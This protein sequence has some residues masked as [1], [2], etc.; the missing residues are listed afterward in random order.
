[1]SYFRSLTKAVTFRPVLVVVFSMSLI[2]VARER[3]GWPAHSRLIKLNSRRSTG[4]HLLGT[5]GIVADRNG[6][7]VGSG[8]G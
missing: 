8:N 5:R 6:E 7:S 2:I 1:M 4:F 3:S